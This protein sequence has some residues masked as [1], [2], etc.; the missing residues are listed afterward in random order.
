M[1]V[2]AYVRMYVS[3]SRV[4]LTNTHHMEVEQAAQPVEHPVSNVSEPQEG[5]TGNNYAEDNTENHVRADAVYLYGV[6][7]LH[8]NDIERYIVNLHNKPFQIEWIDDSSLNLVY[9][10]PNDAF[11]CLVA[12]T[13]PI[14]F[15]SATG[16]IPAGQLRRLKPIPHKPEVLLQARFAN[17]SDRKESGSRAKSRYYLFHG[18]PTRKEDLV[19][20]G[21]KRTA[22][23]M[24][25][26]TKGREIAS[27]IKN[28]P[29]GGDLFPEKAPSVPLDEDIMDDLLPHLAG[30]SKKGRGSRRN[31]RKN[32]DL[33]DLFGNKGKSVGGSGPK[34][35]TDSSKSKDSDVMD[36]EPPADTPAPSVYQNMDY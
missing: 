30:K 6:D 15:D 14:E 20:F 13:D 16:P 22:N 17:D 4:Q 27:D 2:Y 29:R 34:K 23:P 36:A 3:S 28:R 9:D 8:T 19:R 5:S 18:E 21:T 10:D 12:M 33:P 7:E 32:R 11:Q 31:R 25:Y 35:A 24:K 1:Y 26:G